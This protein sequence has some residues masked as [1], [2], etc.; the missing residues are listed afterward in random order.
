MFLFL[1]IHWYLFL[2][3]GTSLNMPPR[4]TRDDEELLVTIRRAIQMYKKG[5]WEKTT[6]VYN[7]LAVSLAT[8][9]KYKTLILSLRSAHLVSVC[10]NI[11]PPLMLT[12][13]VISSEALIDIT[14]PA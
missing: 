5:T 6:I 1:D 8:V 4:F 13:L 3:I 9:K 14:I 2:Y 12:C 7:C 10:F 11:D